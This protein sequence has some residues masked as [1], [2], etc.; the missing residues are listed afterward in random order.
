MKRLNALL[1]EKAREPPLSHFV[2]ILVTSLYSQFIMWQLQIL[3]VYYV[4]FERLDILGLNDL[5]VWGGRM[6]SFKSSKKRLANDQ[7]FSKWRTCGNKSKFCRSFSSV[8]VLL[9]CCHPCDCQY[10]CFCPF[11]WWFSLFCLELF[12]G[13]K[14]I[15]SRWWKHTICFVYVTCGAFLLVQAVGYNSIEAEDWEIATRGEDIGKLET[16]LLDKN[17]KMEHELT[18]VKV[19]RSF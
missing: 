7:L 2:L 1:N 12:R 16:L 3:P 17:R 13:M 5:S 9:M 15:F 11:W 4:T 10:M 6:L 18:Q 14:H 8:N 19:R